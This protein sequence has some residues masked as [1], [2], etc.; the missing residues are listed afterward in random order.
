[1]KKGLAGP[2][3]AILAITAMCFLTFSIGALTVVPA[4]AQ[5]VSGK[6]SGKPQSERIP[7]SADG[8]KTRHF[9]DLLAGVTTGTAWP[10]SSRYVVTNS[11][12]VSEGSKVTLV[13]SQGVEIPA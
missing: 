11:H 6:F 1:M 9:D 13:S 8:Q 7:G 12:V 4:V 10:I 5:S 2:I 3:R